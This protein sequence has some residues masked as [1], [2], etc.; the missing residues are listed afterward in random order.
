MKILLTTTAVASLVVLAPV[1]NANTIQIQYQVGNNP[2]TTCSAAS[3]GPVTC[4]NVAGP[5]LKIVGLDAA[6]NNPGTSTIAV[7]T[8]SDVDLVNNGTSFLNIQIQ[9]S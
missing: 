8:S 1:A 5:P 7:M 2:I 3:P 9:I 4:L 6:S